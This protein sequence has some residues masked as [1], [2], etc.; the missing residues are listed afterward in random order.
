MIDA[1]LAVALA[2][3]Y[4]P[5]SS[6]SGNMNFVLS[7][8]C[9]YLNMLPEEAINAATINSAYALELSH[10]HGSII[11]GKTGSVFITEEMPSYGYMPYSFGTS[12]VERV[13]IE[14]RILK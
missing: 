3:D 7:L 9:L 6:P 11:K 2:S 14:G 13:I 8:A 1:G 5:G 12:K 10:S 4:N